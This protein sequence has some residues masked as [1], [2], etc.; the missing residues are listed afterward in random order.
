MNENRPGVSPNFRY[1]VRLIVGGYLLYT[2]YSVFDYFMS[3]TGWEKIA[4]GAVLV[5]FIVA[6]VYLIVTSLK[7][8][9]S[10]GNKKDQSKALSDTEIAGIQEKTEDHDLPESASDG[11]LQDK[12]QTDSEED[13][14]D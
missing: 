2:D 6:G 4:L 5:L 12:D 10:S 7:E 8:L 3:L 9:I 11:S 13:K 14:G 1:T